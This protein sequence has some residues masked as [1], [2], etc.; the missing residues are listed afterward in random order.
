M[1]TLENVEKQLAD[2]IVARGKVTDAISDA[3][4]IRAGLLCPYKVGDV[5]PV[6]GFSYRGQICIVDKIDGLLDSWK[7]R[8]RVLVRIFKKDGTPGKIVHE[9]GEREEG[10]K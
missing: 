6:K 9:W 1:M 7:G 5:V 10:E 4:Q 3:V 8:W 2:L